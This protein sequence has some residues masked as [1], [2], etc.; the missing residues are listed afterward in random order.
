MFLDTYI[1]IYIYIYVSIHILPCLTCARLLFIFVGLSLPRGQWGQE[2][3][4]G[5]VCRAGPGEDLPSFLFKE[6]LK[7]QSAVDRDRFRA[8]NR[9]GD[10]RAV[11][12][13]AESGLVSKTV[14]K[15]SQNGWFGFVS[16]QRNPQMLVAFFW[17]P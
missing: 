6:C 14:G 2:N 3:T 8:R 7:R 11:W 16:K 4:F 9:R 15:P 1:Y 12:G 13:V 5:H 17:F 10:R